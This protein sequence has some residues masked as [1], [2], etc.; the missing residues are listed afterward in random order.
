M[1]EVHQPEAL[2]DPNDEPTL[3]DEV[4]LPVEGM[5]WHNFFS[6]V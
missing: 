1:R 2:S 3:V 5:E 4:E 6:N